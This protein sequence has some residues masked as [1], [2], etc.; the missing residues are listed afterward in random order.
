MGGPLVKRADMPVRALHITPDK[1]NE[2]ENKYGEI[3]NRLQGLVMHGGFRLITRIHKWRI[4]L[5]ELDDVVAQF[6]QRES[7]QTPKEP[8]VI[9][10]RF[11]PSIC[12]AYK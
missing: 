2:T 7:Y 5:A 1:D 9:F 6:D 8:D 3:S 11:T 4:Q 12:M 10:D